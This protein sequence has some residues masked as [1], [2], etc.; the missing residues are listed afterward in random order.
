MTAAAQPLSD[1]CEQ[2]FDAAPGLATAAATSPRKSVVVYAMNYAPETAGV[3]KYTGEIAEYLAAEGMDVTVVTTP[4]HYPGWSVQPGYRN[5]YSLKIEGRITVLRAPL[6][7][8]RKMSGIWRLLAPLSF[9]LTSAPL[10]FWQ[11]LRRRPVTVFCV[12]PTLF[13]APAAQLAARLIGARTVLHVHD[14]EVDAAFAVGHLSSKAWLKT[15]GH[16]FERSVLGRF[17]RLITISNRMAEGLASKG[18]PGAKVSVVRNWVDLV[19]IHPM[20][21]VSPYR[22]E[23]GFGAKDFVVLYSGSIGAKQG[24]NV[25]LDA[26]ERLKDERH[27]H[28]VI[29]G[30]GPQKPELEARYGHLAN[31]RFLA[32][33]PYARLNALLNMPDLHVLPQDRS[34][35]DLALPSKLGGMLASGKPV[36]VTADAGTE[37]AQFVDDAVYLTP[38]NDPENLAACIFRAMSERDEWQPHS[39]TALVQ[40]LSKRPAILAIR[41]LIDGGEP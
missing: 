11:I 16:V 24:L 4:P 28:F 7:L 26:A 27:I 9:A 22:A 31:V 19:H 36:L 3:G 40:S 1:E 35:A 5:R 20:E 23:L 10:V 18:V 29:S 41:E 15:L 30:E 17:D 33:Q 25:L 38:P 12:E 39:R 13:A 21:E 8:R 14:M 6:L 34:A 32:F 2:T 37:L